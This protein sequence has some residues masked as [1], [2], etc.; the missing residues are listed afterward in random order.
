MIGKAAKKSKYSQDLYSV[1]SVLYS[2]YPYQ[3]AILP[4]S[5]S[6]TSVR[7]PTNS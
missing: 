7:A 3:Y 6:V 1:Q 4:P 5:F 2:K